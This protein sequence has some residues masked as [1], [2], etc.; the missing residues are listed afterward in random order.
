VALQS[1]FK[2]P[3]FCMIA[4]HDPPTKIDLVTKHENKCLFPFNHHGVR[5]ESLV[6]SYVAGGIGS[7]RENR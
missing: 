7:L 6:G 5:A 4:D 3:R 1:V 2:K